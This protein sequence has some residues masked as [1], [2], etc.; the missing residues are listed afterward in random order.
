MGPAASFFNPQSISKGADQQACAVFGE[1][2][3]LQQPLV[4]CTGGQF[5]E[6]AAVEGNQ[7][8]CSRTN[9]Q[10]P[11]VREQC[12]NRLRRPI[13]PAIATKLRA[14][15]LDQPLG[16]R[17]DEELRVEDRETE[18]VTFGQTVDHR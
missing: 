16:A 17:P 5:L 2:V 7:A 18:Q 13:S 6:L 9:E 12:V 14:I 8:S 11:F 3:D 1:Q 15:K 4:L 10:T